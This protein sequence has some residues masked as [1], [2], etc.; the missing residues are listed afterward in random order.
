[1][2]WNKYKIQTELLVT[3]KCIKSPINIYQ[4]NNCV[5]ATVIEN[6]VTECIA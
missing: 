2:L 5:L 6:D 3:I 1:M 4:T